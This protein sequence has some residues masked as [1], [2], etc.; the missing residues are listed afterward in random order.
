M[1]E[2]TYN[3]E[4]LKDLEDRE[5]KDRHQAQAVANLYMAAAMGFAIG[6]YD[7]EEEGGAYIFRHSVPIIAP[8]DHE[9]FFVAK[10]MRS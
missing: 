8:T 3:P 7:E 6:V 5:T 1:Q 2:L 9:R 10:E 4:D